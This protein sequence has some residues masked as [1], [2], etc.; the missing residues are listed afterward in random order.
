MTEIKFL[1]GGK[2]Q[3]VT[4][5]CELFSWN[6]SDVE[7]G[8][9]YVGVF[10]PSGEVEFVSAKISL[11]QNY[12]ESDRILC[13]GI[14]SWTKTMELTPCDV[15]KHLSLFAR[16]IDKKMNIT[17]SGDKHIYDYPEKKGF[18][19]SHKYIYVRNGKH[20][21]FYGALNEKACFTMFETNCKENVM[22]VI[23]DVK[24]LVTDKPRTLFDFV[25]LDG[26]RG[27]V[28]D[29]FFELMEIAPPRVKKAKGWTSWYNYYQNI[30]EEIIL[31]NC[32]NLR[33]FKE[34]GHDIDIFQIDDGFE[35]YVGDWLKV[36]KNKF[37]RGLKPIAE[38]INKHFTAGLWLAPF[39]AEAKSSLYREHRDWILK[40]KD[41]NEVLAGGNWSGFYA[42]DFYNENVREYLREVFKTVFED[43][44]FKM[45]K[46]DFL[47]AACLAVPKD[48]TRSEV[49]REAMEF[50]REL[51][52][53][54]IVL[55]CGVPLSSA[56][57]LVDYCRVGCDVSLD[58]SYY[59]ADN[60]IHKECVSTRCAITDSVIR[61]PLSGRAFMNDP[62]VFLLRT[63][64]IK[65]P[66]SEKLALSIANA[67]FGRVLFT[68]DD[69]SKYPDK[70]V[71]DDLEYVWHLNDCK[72]LDYD[73]I[74][75]DLFRA[76]VELDG[77][78]FSYYINVSN[79]AY[80]VDGIKIPKRSAT[81]A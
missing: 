21:R 79:H 6:V 45:V 56:Y 51:C 27:Y 20:Y 25:I 78:K 32:E 22:T 16:M 76:D 39:A 53:D 34:S 66:R 37:P 80:T 59:G 49:M 3:T 58:W 19:H 36:D 55:G 13:N 48:K 15:E 57:G 31:R 52:G 24:G 4:S 61:F 18:I 26:E 38:E 17:L 14:Q 72:L 63:D 46:L 44:G 11:E 65:M 35:E 77:E 54:N 47:Y 43:W 1:S 75:K 12:G 71:F 10:T 9:R 81:K 33:K 23:A 60:F 42:L 5:P 7:G 74:E 70:S 2:L 62:D 40:D 73:F 64:N 50:I 30:D 69:F 68:S 8:K 67:I 28:Y 29:R 41:G